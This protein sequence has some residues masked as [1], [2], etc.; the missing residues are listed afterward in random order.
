ML[1][2]NGLNEMVAYLRNPFP[3]LT[4]VLEKKTSEPTE[5]YNCIAWA[6]KDNQRKWW[7]SRWAFWPIDYEGKTELEAFEDWFVADGW[8]ET[9]D[10]LVEE[11]Y[12]KIALYTL[13]GEPKHA[14]RL[15]P[16]GLWTSKLGSSLDL[17]HGFADLDGPAYGSVFKIFRKKI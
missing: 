9:S 13:D 11:G 6:F 2:L 3:K 16:N 10:S 7:P 14:A 8:E 5:A 4:A 15:L 12:E 17:S 1:G